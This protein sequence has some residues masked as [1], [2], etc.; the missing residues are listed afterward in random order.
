MQSEINLRFHSF[1]T[2]QDFWLLKEIGQVKST[3]KFWEISMTVEHQPCPRDG[4]YKG[5]MRACWLLVLKTRHIKAEEA[6]C[7]S[8]T[9]DTCQ[10]CCQ[11]RNLIFNL[12]FFVL[13]QKSSLRICVPKL[14]INNKI[15]PMLHPNIFSNFVKR[16]FRQT[17]QCWWL[18]LPSRVSVFRRRSNHRGRRFLSSL[19]FLCSRTK[20]H[21]IS[22][23]IWF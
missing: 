14:W 5:P 6:C 16:V 23:S 19:R 18:L 2:Q 8:H 1:F 21:S 3:T 15:L 20:C 9:V 7:Y 13:E 11:R 4:K 17:N 10:I 22:W 12:I